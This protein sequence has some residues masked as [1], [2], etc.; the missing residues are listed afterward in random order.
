MAVL[1]PTLLNTL[2]IQ[3]LWSPVIHFINIS[4]F[5]LP[6]DLSLYD[7]NVALYSVTLSLI[8]CSKSWSLETILIFEPGNFS[9][10]YLVVKYIISSASSCGI[11]I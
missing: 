1:G 7:F 11:L 3:S 9:S 5:L 4:R 2:G 6:S 8:N 10:M